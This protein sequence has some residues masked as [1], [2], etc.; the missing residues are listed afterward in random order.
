[1]EQNPGTALLSNI[2]QLAAMGIQSQPMV[3][4]SDSDFSICMYSS[5]R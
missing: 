1:M 5:S 4:M 2:S 3:I